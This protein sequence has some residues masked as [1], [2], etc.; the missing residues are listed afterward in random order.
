[1]IKLNSNTRSS[2]HWPSGQLLF[3]F[4]PQKPY[5]YNEN[6]FFGYANIIQENNVK[7]KLSNILLIDIGN[8]SVAIGIGS[9]DNISGAKRILTNQCTTG[10]V[11]KMIKSFAL[12]KHIS[13]AVLCSVVPRVNKVWRKEIIDICGVSP[14]EVGYRLNLGVKIEYPNPESIGADRLADACGAISRYNPPIIV[15]DFGTALTFDVI[16]RDSKY[17]GG[18]IAPGLP[19]M[20]DY[21][22]EK[23]ALLPRIKLKGQC[24]KIGRSTISAMLIGAKIGYRGI[25]REVTNHLITGLGMKRVKLLATGGY[26]QWALQG[27]D[28]PFELDP[29]LTLYGLLKIYE[30]N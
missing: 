25:V 28:M 22:A 21:L 27:L 26:A 16:S 7:R 30:L 11:K 2:V 19:L 14:I 18:V 23:T 9:A 17:I 29:E 1:M 8:T 10:V 15:A 4:Y 5:L 12:K 13:G 3:D 24:H 6:T 20:T